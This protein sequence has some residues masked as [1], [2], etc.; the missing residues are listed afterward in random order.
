MAYRRELNS[1]YVACLNEEGRARTCGYWYTVTSRSTP[2]TAFRSRVAFL[3]W[4]ELRGLSVKPNAQGV[5]SLPPQGNSAGFPIGGAYQTA[6]HM[7]RDEWEA[8]EGVAVLALS[9]GNYTLAKLAPDANGT[10]CEHILN[11]NVHDRP[12]FDYQVCARLIDEG[13]A[14]DIPPAVTGVITR[15][16]AAPKAIAAASEHD[17]LTLA[18]VAACLW[19][20]ALD[21]KASKTPT[22]ETV[23]RY[24]EANGTANVRLEVCQLASDCE[25]AWRAL[26]EDEQDKAG[27]FDWE[28]CPDWLASRMSWNA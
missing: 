22:G 15:E 23:R 14:L 6:L 10:I 25:T 27:A 7:D 9:N 20:A 28:F 3:Q 26:S 12:V 8:V 19:E 5:A 18:E 11:P 2:E 16:I 4:L 21:L 24:F 17:A 1:L 13:R